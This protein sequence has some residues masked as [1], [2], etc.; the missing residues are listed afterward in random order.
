VSAAER[1]RDEL[2][3]TISADGSVSVRVLVA[4]RL[5]RDAARRHQTAPTA[6]VALG[7]A[8]MG[9]LLLATEAQDG[10][11]VQAQWRGDGPLGTITVTGASDGAVRGY[12]SRPATDLPLAA[13][14]FDVAR[15][16][17]LGLLTVERNH[18]E[19]KQ[20]YSGIVPIVSGEI[21]TDLAHYLLESEQKPSSVALGVFLDASGEV[22]AAG[23]H[24]VQ[25][26]PGADDA[27]L[28]VFE[29]RI[30]ALARP[31]ELVRE[32]ATA[33]MLL[34]RLVGGL[35]ARNVS[36]VAPRFR[37]PCSME[38]VRRALAFLGDDEIRDVVA[39]QETLEVRCEFCAEIYYVPPD[40]VA[41]LA[42]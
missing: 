31:S 6:T 24:L 20:P 17:G 26:L 38:R 13:E 9:A 3:R 22:L 30:A 15:A 10:E 2:L 5:V 39:K 7:R 27:A 42:G 36:R 21:A 25:S 12:V 35:G 33:A 1:P 18:P 14:R 23:G 11:C 8:L 40:R 34:D 37:C 28:R 4:T 29:Q 32:G 16:V 19:W 41:A